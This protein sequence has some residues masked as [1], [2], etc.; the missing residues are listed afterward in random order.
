MSPL[1]RRRSLPPETIGKGQHQ[2]VWWDPRALEL[3]RQDEAGLRQQRI[4]AA[5]QGSLFANEGARLYEQ[6]R[7]ARTKALA[8]G[9]VPTLRVRSVTEAR[10][11][12][13][14][15]QPVEVLATDAER[16]TRPRGRRFGSLVHAIL[17]T[18]PLDVAADALAVHARTLSRMFSATEEEVSAAVDAVTRALAHPLMV[19]ARA[20][21]EVRR[22]SPVA[23]C[24]PQGETIEGVLDLALLEEGGWTVVDFKT[25][26]ELG[27]RRDQYA[28]QVALYADAVA[29]AT[30]LPARGVLLMV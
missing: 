12:A 3:D 1:A 27:D 15:A 14:A 7:D 13:G 8:T 9:A 24:D 2:I 4:L 25:D 26:A 18:V 17:A 19:R 29:K 21:K 23:V 22:E 10:A 11:E 6:W 16:A 20:A 28:A 5:D 30:G